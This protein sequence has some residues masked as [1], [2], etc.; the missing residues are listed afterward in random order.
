M[1]QAGSKFAEATRR[2]NVFESQDL[3]RPAKLPDRQVDVAAL[4]PQTFRILL[5][6]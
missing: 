3:T 2:A 6:P 5:I 4:P 1:P